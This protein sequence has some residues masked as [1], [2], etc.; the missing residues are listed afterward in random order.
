[1]HYIREAVENKEV[2]LFYVPTNSQF[3]DIF[4]K[5]LSHHKFEDGR[6]ALK[7]KSYSSHS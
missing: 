5:N 4:T 6:K 1:M 2:T 3:A 7:L